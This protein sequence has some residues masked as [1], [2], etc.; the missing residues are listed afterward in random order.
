MLASLFLLNSTEPE[1]MDIQRAHFPGKSEF[2]VCS[3]E[4]MH[5]MSGIHAAPSFPLPFFGRIRS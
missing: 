2:Q 4:G 3:W 1:L 5:R